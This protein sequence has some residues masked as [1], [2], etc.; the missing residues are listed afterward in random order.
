MVKVKI[1]KYNFSFVLKMAVT[2]LCEVN[3]LI[4]GPLFFFLES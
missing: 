3:T 1:D 2:Y 4:N